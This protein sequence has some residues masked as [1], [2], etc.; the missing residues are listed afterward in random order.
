MGII[1]KIGVYLYILVVY[2]TKSV[3][4]KIVTTK[5]LAMNFI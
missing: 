2:G 4:S 3:K 5:G 1:F